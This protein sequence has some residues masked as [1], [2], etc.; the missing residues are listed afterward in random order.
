MKSIV[1]LVHGFTIAVVIAGLMSTLH[2]RPTATRL[3]LEAK[4]ATEK[5][6]VPVCPPNDPNAC[7]IDKW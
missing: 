2:L 6:P 4:A 3:Y 7:H 1:R 5:M